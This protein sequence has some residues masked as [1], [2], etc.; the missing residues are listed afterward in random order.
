MPPTEPT[1]QAALAAAT[2]Q[3][4]TTM[5]LVV[6]RVSENLG[7]LAKSSA[8]IAERDLMNST[9]FELRRKINVF[10]REFAQVLREK[11]DQQLVP[12]EDARRTIQ[13][14]ISGAPDENGA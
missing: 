5:E 11:I 4:T 12:R 2:N 1:L 3:L 10:H 14:V 9:Q 6:N 8:R 7:V 13:D